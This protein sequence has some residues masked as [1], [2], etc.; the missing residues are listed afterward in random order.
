MSVPDDHVP[1]IR[2]SVEEANTRSRARGSARADEAANTRLRG[3]GE[4]IFH[5]KKFTVSELPQIRASVEEANTSPTAAHPLSFVSLP[6]I[7]A[8]VEEANTWA[9]G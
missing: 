9:T 1:Q 6:Q 3:G 8:S 4:H 5:P 2:A 7:R